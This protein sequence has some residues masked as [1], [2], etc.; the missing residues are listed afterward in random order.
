MIQACK[1]KIAAIIRAL[2]PLFHHSRIHFPPFNSF[3]QL[4][5]KHSV[6]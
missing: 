5:L 6:R 3:S 4:M 2:R 1:S